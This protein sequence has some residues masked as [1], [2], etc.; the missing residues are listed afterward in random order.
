MVRC[1]IGVTEF[2]PGRHVRFTF[3][4]RTGLDGWHEF[5]VEERGGRSL[6]RHSLIAQPVGVM[7]VFMPLAV[8]SVHDAVIEDAFDRVEQAVAESVASPAV[9]S[10]KVRFWH[11]AMVNR[12]RRVG[13]K[14]SRNAAPTA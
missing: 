12:E 4:P 7:W 3:W 11:W 14:L 6:I 1:V 2:E 9:W 10:K 5:E 13:A 8:E